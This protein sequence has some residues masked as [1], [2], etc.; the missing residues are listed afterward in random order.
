[1][2]DGSERGDTRVERVVRE[3]EMIGV[4]SGEWR[5]ALASGTGVW[6]IAAFGHEYMD[7]SYIT[8]VNE[9]VARI[10]VFVKYLRF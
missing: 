4:S 6:R 3:E 8:T 2:G 1:M 10:S 5:I 9:L 7:R